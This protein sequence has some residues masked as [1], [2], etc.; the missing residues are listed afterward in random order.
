MNLFSRVT[1]FNMKTNKSKIFFYFLVWL[2]T[3]PHKISD[4]LEWLEPIQLF[5]NLNFLLVQQK[6]RSE[7]DNCYRCNIYPMFLTTEKTRKKGRSTKHKCCSYMIYLFCNVPMLYFFLGK[8][9]TE[10]NVSFAWGRN[11]TRALMGNIL[12]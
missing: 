4:L 5:L 6:G 1:K 2:G 7:A 10:A 12:D 9:P 11:N 8:A 3:D